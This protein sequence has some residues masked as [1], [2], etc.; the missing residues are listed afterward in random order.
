MPERHTH[1]NT[2]IDPD[3]R[4]EADWE[5]SSSSI[6]WQLLDDDPEDKT[7]S[8]T[9]FQVVDAGHNED[10]ALELVSYWLEATSP[11]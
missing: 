4:I 9:P 1:T 11:A 5:Q 8:S 6:W 3:I 7:W 2:A 10:R